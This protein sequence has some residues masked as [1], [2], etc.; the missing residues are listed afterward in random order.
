MFVDQIHIVFCPDTYGWL[1]YANRVNT[2]TQI[3]WNYNYNK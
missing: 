1:P 2:R 3:S